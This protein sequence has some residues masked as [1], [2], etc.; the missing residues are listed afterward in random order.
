MTEIVRY[1]SAEDLG[2]KP[3]DRVLVSEAAI[4][5]TATSSF[6]ALKP[7]ELAEREWIITEVNHTIVFAAAIRRDRHGTLVTGLD[8]SV[9]TDDYTHRYFPNSAPIFQP[10][11]SIEN[12]VG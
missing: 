6:H 9:L 1:S 4:C 8:G 12:H 11:S 10:V 3:G 2:L 7:H 5:S